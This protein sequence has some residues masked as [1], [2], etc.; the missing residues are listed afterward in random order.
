MESLIK[1]GCCLVIFAAGGVFMN[2]MIALDYA[3]ISTDTAIWKP[4][5]AAFVALSFC[6]RP[7]LSPNSL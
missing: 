7:C 6:L 5:A 2:H 1:F 3:V 4:F